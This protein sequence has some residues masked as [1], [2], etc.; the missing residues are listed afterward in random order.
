MTYKQD[1]FTMI[2]RP[3][4]LVRF[5]TSLALS[6]AVQQGIISYAAQQF[7]VETAN[8]YMKTLLSGKG[9]VKERGKVS[10]VIEHEDV[11]GGLTGVLT[12]GDDE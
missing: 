10:E 9:L 4:D 8:S 11:P 7:V 5:T 3:E 12:I 1:D 2:E 6:D